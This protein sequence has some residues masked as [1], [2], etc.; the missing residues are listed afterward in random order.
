MREIE[1]SYTNFW[2]THNPDKFIIT[3]I[4]RKHYN[5]N[6]IDPSKVSNKT[7]LLIIGCHR[8]VI[9]TIYPCKTLYYTG[10]NEYIN[11]NM[12]DYGIGISNMGNFNR[13]L[14]IP[15]WLIDCTNIL[16]KREELDEPY[17]NRDFCSF[18]VSN[19]Y[20]QIPVRD[21][22]FKK[23][24]E[25]KQVASGGRYLNNIGGPVDNKID[26]IKKYKFNIA[27]ENSIVD[28]YITEKIGDAFVAR[29]IPIYCGDKYV[30]T[31]FNN[32]SFINVNDYSSYSELVNDIKD[33]DS[34]KDRY[35]EILNAPIFNDKEYPYIL[36]EQIEE[37]M[38]NIIEK[39]IKYNH[40]FGRMGI[41][42]KPKL[43]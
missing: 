6:I 10:E 28:G 8:L 11:F 15:L 18:V 1:I 35:L 16:D 4:L 31:D 40:K 43:K 2:P 14:R 19:N 32:Q 42:N 12:F 7:D 21:M 30:T 34:N 23:I 3:E 22:L 33:I 9:P 13:Y 24:S 25:Y 5:V 39:D 26:F 17:F 38:T 29:T 36:L 41:I 37:F 20:C 27:S